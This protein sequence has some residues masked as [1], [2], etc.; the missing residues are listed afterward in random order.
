MIGANRTQPE[1][2]VNLRATIKR[3]ERRIGFPLTPS[4]SHARAFR[5]RAYRIYDPRTLVLSLL[6][7]REASSRWKDFPSRYFSITRSNSPSYALFTLPRSGTQFVTSVWAGVNRS[8]DGQVVAKGD[9]IDISFP[10]LASDLRNLFHGAYH[11]PRKHAMVHGHHPIQWANLVDFKHVRPVFS[12]RNPMDAL[13][14]WVVLKESQRGSLPPLSHWISTAQ[15]IAQYFSWWAD[16]I[17]NKQAGR[18]FHFFR[19]ED[20]VDDPLT[21]FQGVFNFYG[22]NVDADILDRVVTE[23]SYANTRK[24]YLN[25][26]NDYTIRVTNR[27][28]ALPPQELSED[29]HTIFVSSKDA[30]S[31]FGYDVS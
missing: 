18:D 5:F 14:S 17:N 23:N 16:F 21:T 6:F 28:Y 20:L 30:F 4:T 13:K 1:T 12:V 10:L 9:L 29:I 24:K 26:S 2:N 8:M 22:R 31:F 19:Y 11:I 25:E 3:V 27:T 15:S 7:C